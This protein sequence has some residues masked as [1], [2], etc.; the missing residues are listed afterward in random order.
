MQRRDQVDNHIAEVFKPMPAWISSICTW[1]I[2]RSNLYASPNRAISIHCIRGAMSCVSVAFVAA[3]N[4]RIRSSVEN[5]IDLLPLL[6]DRNTILRQVCN[7][8]LA[9]QR[10]NQTHLHSASQV[11]LPLVFT[12]DSKTNSPKDLWR[13]GSVFPYNLLQTFQSCPNGQKS[14]SVFCV[15]LCKEIRA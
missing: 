2:S 10:P 1:A 5:G 4:P 13:D 7:L 8:L 14:E 11:Q 3:S 12:R 6:F 9:V 15:C